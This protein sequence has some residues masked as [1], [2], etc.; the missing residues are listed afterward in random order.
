MEEE[1][2][3]CYVGV[4]RAKERLYLVRAFRRNLM[5][6]S[7][8]NGPSRFLSDVPRH[9]IQGAGL[10][11]GGESQAA[12]AAYSWDTPVAS[13]FTNMELKAGDRVRHATFGDGVVVSCGPVQ[14]DGEVVVAFAEAG[15]K[16]LLLSLA[17][18]EKVEEFS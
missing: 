12:R 2:R 18:L 10:W 7:T 15:V 11:E 3:L 16:K 5:G 13:S 4:T 9:L 8:V 17:H 1:R 6:S 14:D